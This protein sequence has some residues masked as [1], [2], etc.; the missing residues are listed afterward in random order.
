[1][2]RNI[3]KSDL[4]SLS[5]ITDFLIFTGFFCCSPADEDHDL[6]NFIHNDAESHL[7]NRMAVTYGFFVE[8]ITEPLGFTTLQND[9]IK[10]QTPGYLYKSSPAVK[11]GRLG[12]N[13]KIQGHGFGGEL[14]FMIK[15]FMLTNNRTG[16]RYITLDAYN[17]SRVLNFYIKNGFKPLKEIQT[18]RRQVLM[19]FDLKSHVSI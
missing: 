10:V 17:N 3:H 9:S 8:G 14:M 4:F 1:M 13:N 7:M 11:V 12:I 2:N 19:Y 18:T 15:E 16:C 5:P 6:D